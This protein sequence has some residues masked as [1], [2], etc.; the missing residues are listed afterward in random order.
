LDF[1]L[2]ITNL[3]TKFLHIVPFNDR[4]FDLFGNVIPG[5]VLYKHPTYSSQ[6]DIGVEIYEHISHLHQWHVCESMPER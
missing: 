3:I 2:Q 1:W 6:V 4:L 5:W